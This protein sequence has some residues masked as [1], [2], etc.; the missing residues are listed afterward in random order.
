MLMFQEAPN[1]MIQTTIKL[2][3]TTKYQLAR[4]MALAPDVI[5]SAPA[6]RA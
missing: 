5:G 3:E 4:G 1:N 2:L 6:V